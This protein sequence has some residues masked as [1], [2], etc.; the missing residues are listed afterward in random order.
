MTAHKHPTPSPVVASLSPLGLAANPIGA[1]SSRDASVGPTGEAG[2]PN[3]L[4]SMKC[5]ECDG[6]G[7]A[8]YMALHE[9]RYHWRRCD[10]CDGSGEEA[11]YCETCGGKLT[12]DLFCY[13]CDDYGL[14]FVERIAPGRIAL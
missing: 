3:L 4:T 6:K 8:E 13:P 14:V 5:R 12:V 2:A 9:D 10:K 11:P 7:E 1:P